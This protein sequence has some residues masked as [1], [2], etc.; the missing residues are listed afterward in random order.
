MKKILTIIMS[1]LFCFLVSCGTNNSSSVDEMCTVQLAESEYYEVLTDNPVEVKKGA[2]AAFKVDIIDGREFDYSDYGTFVKNQSIFRVDNVQESC[3]VSFETRH[4]GDCALTILNNDFKGRYELTPNKESYEA[5]DVVTV[6]VFTKED[7]FM[8]YTFER[9]YRAEGTTE[10]TS[11][12]VAF[13]EKFTFTIEDDTTLYMNYFI[14]GYAKMN[15]DANG[16]K[17]IDGKDSFAIDY[18]L[19]NNTLNPVTMLGTYY[20]FRDGYTL[21]SYNTKADGTGIRVGIGSKVDYEHFENNEIT[22]YAQWK[23]WTDE[24]NFE[25]EDLDEN[26]VTIKKYNGY[27]S[28]KEIVIPNTINGKLV[29]KIS[30]KAFEN[31]EVER[32]VLNLD[33]VTIIDN[34]FI[35]CNNLK[36]LVMFTNVESISKTSINSTTS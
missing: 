19:N 31:I 7:D 14:D 12:P 5:G 23:K 36:S 6:E 22:L 15:Y 35:N 16:G 21:E 9:K 27:S 3:V 20:L 34:A 4:I 33:L 2:S 8:C 25:V 26:S 13:E 1:F 18:R 10:P 29:K 30:E 17:T 32:L 28:L 24:S 11:M